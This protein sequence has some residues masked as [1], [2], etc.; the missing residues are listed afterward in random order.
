MLYLCQCVAVI[1]M[2]FH[3]SSALLGISSLGHEQQRVKSQ[4]T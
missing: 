2:T 3:Y 4:K 1:P